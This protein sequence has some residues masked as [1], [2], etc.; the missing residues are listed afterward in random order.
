MSKR[1]F[2]VSEARYFARGATKWDP[3]VAN[4]HRG[5][6]P[7]DLCCVGHGKNTLKVFR[8]PADRPQK[9]PAVCQACRVK[10][11]RPVHRGGIVCKR[12]IAFPGAGSSCVRV[13]RPPALSYKGTFC[14][15]IGVGIQ[16]AL[17]L[18]KAEG[19]V[20]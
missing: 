17:Q 7:G 1:S 20:V 13:G 10:S 12:E 11:N 19:T 14:H 8:Y 16:S 5:M 15:V 18:L 3:M 6:R 4:R 2:V 9:V